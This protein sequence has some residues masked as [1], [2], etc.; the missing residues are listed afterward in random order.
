MIFEEYIGLKGKIEE[1]ILTPTGIPTTG[2]SVSII[3]IKSELVPSPPAKTI[4]S[5][6]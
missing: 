1:Y 3:L 5:T 6:F 2:I 4:K